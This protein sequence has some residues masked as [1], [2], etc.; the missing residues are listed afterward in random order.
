MAH[1]ITLAITAECQGIG[2]L[3][4]D[5]IDNYYTDNSNA[6]I[7]GV[8]EAE[9]IEEEVQTHL[10]TIV[11]ENMKNVMVSTDTIIVIETIDL[12][13]GDLGL[14][15]RTDINGM[16]AQ[17]S[18]I[19][20]EMVAE[21]ADPIQEID[22][23]VTIDSKTGIN[24]KAEQ[25]ATMMMIEEITDTEATETIEMT[26]TK[27]EEIGTMIV[28][29]EI[30]TEAE[31]EILSEEAT[32]AEEAET[33]NKEIE[34]EMMI[35]RG[36]CEKV[37]VSNVELKVTWLETA[38]EEATTTNNLEEDMTMVVVTEVIATIEASIE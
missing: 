19:A 22:T 12:E 13:V 18:I 15:H 17:A 27:I 10:E 25:T 33:F 24:T 8:I 36:A 4:S 5:E 11:K 7:Q 23:V 30:L 21:E 32:E 37:S 26:D 14:H 3:T 20:K 35:N 6:K 34:W 2:K 31:E 28:I 29:E 16:N 9:G 1:E 38:K